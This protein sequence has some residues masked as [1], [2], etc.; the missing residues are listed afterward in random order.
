MHYRK[1]SLLISVF[2]AVTL[3]FLT[4]SP[5]EANTPRLPDV[6]QFMDERIQL[7][8]E[9]LHI[10]NAAIAVVA[11]GEVVFLK[12][13][14]YADLEE[15][16][17]VN[18]ENTLFRIGS[19]AKLV[20]WTAVMQLVE[21]GQLD[22]HAD[23]NDYL[24]FQIPSRLIDARGNT[25]PAPVTLAHL[26]THS[27]GFEAYPDQIFRLSSGQ[28]LPLDEYV[29]A[30]LPARVFPPGEVS[31]YSNYGTALAGYIVQ[32]VSGQPFA[33]Y[34]EQHI[35]APLNMDHSTFRQP[36]PGELSANRAR[37]YRFVEGVY[38]PGEFEYMQEPEGS[39]S[40][41]AADMANFM[42]AH[43][44]GGSFNGGRILQEETVR[45]MHSR[46]PSRHPQLGGMTLGFMEGAFNEQ[47]ILF[48]GGSTM[49]F[50]SGLYLL[51]EENIGLFIVYSG[52]SH[53]AH[54]A[55]FQ[56]F[57]DRYYPS[58][59][60]PAP[61]PAEG[62]LERSRQFTGEYHQNTRS[63]TTAESFTSLMLG[64][65]QIEVD[66]D[67]YLL[68]THVNE[69]N[70]F[71]EIEPGVYQNLREGRTQDYFGPFR[72]LVFETD[73]L[74]RTMLVSDGP[75][76][77]SRAPWYG[78]STLPALILILLLMLVSLIVWGIGFVAGLFK[79]RKLGGRQ[80]LSKAAVSARWVGATFAILTL[81][82]LLGLVSTGAPHPVYLLPAPAFGVLP[83][84]DTLLDTLPW[85][86]V[87][88]GAVVVV[89]NVLA[90]FKGYWRLGARIH[91][92]FFTAAALLLIWIFSYWNVL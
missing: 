75:M 87:F 13:Y 79:G 55:L 91:Y 49:V 42:I 12:G 47:R 62:M 5:V 71:V 10:P 84:W 39:M 68:V 52:A 33:E 73:P 19:T 92:T 70:R 9:A 31:A 88:V 37:P 35:F 56:S 44:Q 26:M 25:E 22:L 30:H 83:A 16:L 48:H 89:F 66:E 61:E 78:T 65:I 41:T 2:L 85:L 40:S 77:Y 23:V 1:R 7:Q 58:A 21:Q 32:R 27:A 18:A 86:L 45:Q 34:V 76:T 67:G 29:R 43:L 60:A 38:L 17:P 20:T 90:W 4:A 57:L 80:A 81:A 54:T 72:T 46:Q 74:G 28:L 59:S 11:D 24:D 50:D 15:R 82:Y 3:L 63:F 64:V 51:P 36:A 6:E 69:T 8:I 53:L 14:G